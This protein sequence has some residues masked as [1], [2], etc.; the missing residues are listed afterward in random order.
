MGLLFNSSEEIS[1]KVYQKFGDRQNY[2]IAMKHNGIAKGIFK[3]I[4]SNLYY[5]LDSS[6]SFVLYFNNKGIYE[7]EISN[8]TKKDFLLMPWNEISSFEVKT[9]LSKTTI[10]F[11]HLGKKIA[12]EI[13]FNGK[14]F[15]DNKHN[16]LKLSEN[17]WNRI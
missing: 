8:S 16:F 12:Y 10:T 11:V 13:P 14:Y 15:I 5:I 4:I 1:E 17:D 6:R 3:W 2:L 9:D 7:S